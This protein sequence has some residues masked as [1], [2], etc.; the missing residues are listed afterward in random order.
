M[1]QHPSDTDDEITPIDI[2]R[3]SDHELLRLLIG[4]QGPAIADPLSDLARASLPEL[5]ARGLSE[6]DALILLAIFEL[7]RRSRKGGPLP[8]TLH[9]PEDAY[10]FLLPQLEDAERERFVV[11]VLDVRNRPRHVAQVAEGSVDHCIVDPRDVFAPAI[12][13]HGTAVLLAHNHPSGDPTPSREDVELTQRLIHAG[14][15]IGLPVLDHIIIATGPLVGERKFVSLAEVGVMLG[16]RIVG[17]SRKRRKAS[18][19]D[20]VASHPRQRTRAKRKK[21][22]RRR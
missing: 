5:L 13:E 11:V 8:Q 16:G 17:R 19:S 18:V 3:L 12:R 22:P 7:G 6:R 20:G 15:V 2:A 14:E 4:E 10:A 21:A 9:A 1:T